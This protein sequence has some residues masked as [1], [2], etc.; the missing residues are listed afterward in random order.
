MQ[1]AVIITGGARRVGAALAVY[2]AEN[3]YDIA[4]HYN[5]S[6]A[7]ALEV[8]KKVRALG[9]VCELFECDLQ[10]TSEIPAFMARIFAKMPNVSALINNASVFE[11]SEFMQT[12]IALFESQFAVNFK[13]P[14]FLTQAFVVSASA[15]ASVVNILDTDISGTGGSH[16]AYL[17]SKKTLADF[18]KMAARELG[19]KVRVNGVCAGIMLPSDEKD[20]EYMARVEK[21]LPLG[22]NADTMDAAAAA[23]F[24]CENRAVTGQLLFIDGGKNLL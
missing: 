19:Q 20:A 11:R 15:S 16:F 2:F 17:L 7:A 22:K 9:R 6:K 12:D 24:L 23:Y 5:T 21:T 8:Q 4:L 14:F 13:A 10:N 18:T 3:G 1:K